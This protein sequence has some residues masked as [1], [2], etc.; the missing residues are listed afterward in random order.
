MRYVGI[1]VMAMSFFLFAG[2]LGQNA[3]A[4]FLGG[5]SVVSSEIGYSL[6]QLA[7][8]ESE[9]DVLLCGE[10][11][12]LECKIPDAPG[13]VDCGCAAT[14]AIAAELDDEDLACAGD[15]LCCSCRCNSCCRD[16]RG[17]RCCRRCSN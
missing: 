15:L 10:G 11:K 17:L 9:E 13:T 4:K 5:A 3:N 12:T 16:P 8:A 14:S 2:I 1:A 7:E 6:V